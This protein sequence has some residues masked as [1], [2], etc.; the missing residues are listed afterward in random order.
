VENGA[1]GD[2]VVKLMGWGTYEI[3]FLTLLDT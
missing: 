3:I 1:I 2:G